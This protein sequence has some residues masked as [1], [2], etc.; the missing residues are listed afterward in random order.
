MG[1]GP[2][3]MLV[4]VEVPRS[5][6]RPLPIAVLYASVAFGLATVVAIFVETPLATF[7]A[8]YVPLDLWN[9]VLDV[10]EWVILLPPH[11]LVGPIA[12][13]VAMLVTMAVPRLR[14]LAP[15]MMTIA[16]VHLFTRLSTNWLKDATGRLRPGE[17]VKK[18]MPDGSFGFD[19][20]VSFPSGHV[21]L[22][23]SLAIPVL[24]VFPKTRVAAI[25]LALIVTF[26][27]LA[28]IAVN[29]HWISDTLA[30]IS[31]VLLVTW[32]AS[33]ISRPAS[34]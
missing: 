14:S 18:G 16:F 1:I 15:G 22:F 8:Q 25:P 29:A 2:T 24:L 34:R 11:P 26:V 19:K 31:Y 28:R 5:D 3:C 12:V 4:G 33:W 6:R 21:V 27:A 23:A 30:S 9:D 20:G 17:W 32:A 13:V 10:L 7:T